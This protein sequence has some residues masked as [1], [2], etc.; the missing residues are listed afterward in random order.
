MSNLSSYNLKLP[1]KIGL[2]GT[3]YAAKVRAETLQADDRAL[4]VAVAGH[5]ISYTAE[6]ARTW[7]MEAMDSWQELVVRPDIDLVIVSTVNRDHGAIAQA[8]LEADKHVV[9]EEPLALDFQ[10][11]EEIVALAEAKG[12][13]LHVEHIELL[14]GLH[15]ALRQYL[16]AIGQV[17]YA[18]YCT[19]NPQHPAPRKWTY[20]QELFGFPFVGAI[21]RLS[22]FTDLFGGVETVS[23]QSHFHNCQ[24]QFYTACLCYGQLRFKSGAI[25]SVTY[26][27]G[28]T[29]WQ[30][31]NVFEV[32]GDRGTLIFDGQTGTLVGAEGTQAIEVGPRRG[33]F[34]K[35]TQMVLDRLVTGT[36][37]YVTPQASLYTLKVADAARRSAEI[38]E[39]VAIA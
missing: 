30:S 39:T 15:Q 4:L 12:K 21:S 17:F 14:G 28:E 20:H 32:S 13:M 38:G 10:Q 9:V 2:V 7:Q 24:S 11:A 31:A 36:P 29:F 37:L 18:R 6:F 3:G 22:R 23:C 26:G 19:I 25:A 8:A 5:T 33:L 35:D 34:A 27:K 16:P 1:V